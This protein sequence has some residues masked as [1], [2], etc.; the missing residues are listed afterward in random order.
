MFLKKSNLKTI[1]FSIWVQ[2]VRQEICSP[3]IL[4]LTILAFTI[5]ISFD[6]SEQRTKK[7]DVYLLFKNEFQSK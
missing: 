2:N 7:I 3:K 1:P 5:Y 6:V 4:I